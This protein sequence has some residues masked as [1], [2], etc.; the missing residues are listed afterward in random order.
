MTIQPEV[1][2][3]L[4]GGFLLLAL[5]A[6][7][8]HTFLGFLFWAVVLALTTWPVYRRL[9][10]FIASRDHHA[11]P[12][13][14][15]T[16]MIGAMILLPLG[17]GLTKAIAE[18]QSLAKM[19]VDAQN[20]GLP[21]PEWLQ[22][23]PVA[24]AWL[25]EL[26]NSSLG[27]P[28]AVK[29]TLHLLQTGTAMAHTKDLASQ[30]LHRVF[31]LFITLLALFFLYRN[32]ETLGRQVLWGSLKLFGDSGVRYAEHAAAAVR[33]TVNGLVL[34]GLVEGLLLGVGY[35]VSGLSH[36]A[37]L[38]AITGVF[39]MIPFA[40]KL[41]LAVCS[42][43]LAASGQAAAGIGLFVFGIVVIL[44]AENYV[45][46]MLIGGSIKLPFLW[47]LLGIFGGL[48][49]FGLLGLFLGPTVMAVVISIWRDSLEDAAI[50]EG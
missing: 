4:L 7:I 11:W 46:P 10:G 31:G 20:A 34:L 33:A 14:I 36:P 1:R 19:L 30:I 21:A 16:L 27:S 3:R 5:G 6:W 18:A 45:R 49:N 25:A 24:G 22:T 8:L 9:T 12:A 28:D 44:V 15:L 43:V 48:E 40:A 2:A 35:A 41:V 32:G 39:A 26:W 17:Y 47:T 42:L 50:S 13:V 23:V 38:G 29:E 37:M